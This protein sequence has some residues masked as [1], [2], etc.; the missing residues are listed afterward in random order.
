MPPFS[1]ESW[2][3]E[4]ECECPPFRRRGKEGVSFSPRTGK[5][6][7]K[8]DPKGGIGG[9][10]V[11]ARLVRRRR[12]S[13]ITRDEE[14][15]SLGQVLALERCM[16]E[17]MGAGTHPKRDG[18]MTRNHA[19]R[20]TQPKGPRGEAE[21][22]KPVGVKRC[23]LV[24]VRTRDE[25]FSTIPREDRWFS[26]CLSSGNRQLV[27]VSASN[28][29]DEE[30]RCS[31]SV[32]RSTSQRSRDRAALRPSIPLPHFHFDRPSGKKG[33]FPRRRVT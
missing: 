25:N 14:K 28:V 15:A 29:L 27:V 30:E 3:D 18:R 8:I 23:K 17:W 5:D 31:T 32:V 19:R 10:M 20:R 22:T 12:A 13:G 33:R 24:L 26:S 9:R 16:D 7:R 1:G 21:T 4:R 6:S 11:A 2:G